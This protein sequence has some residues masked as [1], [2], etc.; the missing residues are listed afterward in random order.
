MSKIVLMKNVDLQSVD[1]FLPAASD[2][3]GE[4][5]L[6]GKVDGDFTATKIAKDHAAF[7]DIAGSVAEFPGGTTLGRGWYTCPITQAESNADSLVL[8]F[9]TADSLTVRIPIRTQS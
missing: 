5:P 3:T 9:K 4:T 8:E 7:A 1:F 2:P 6:T